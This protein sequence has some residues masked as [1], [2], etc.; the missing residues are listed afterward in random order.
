MFEFG[1]LKIF[2]LL[3]LLTRVASGQPDAGGPF[4]LGGNVVPPVPG[5]TG[6]KSGSWNVPVLLNPP[7][8]VQTSSAINLT[9]SN[10][11][12]KAGECEAN[13]NTVLLSRL[14]T[15]WET[16]LNCAHV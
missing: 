8:N 15:T 12:T 10:T 13:K 5:V 2:I 14:M 9:Q 11:E 6:L 1:H 16:L 4:L 3:P 7:S